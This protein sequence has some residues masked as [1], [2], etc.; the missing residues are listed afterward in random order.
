[1]NAGLAETIIDNN[2]KPA[3]AGFLLLNII[4]FT[5]PMNSVYKML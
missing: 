4:M 1:M 5:R 2:K 3:L